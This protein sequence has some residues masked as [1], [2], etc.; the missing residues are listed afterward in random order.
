MNRKEALYKFITDLVSNCSRFGERATDSYR[1]VRIVR[2]TPIK[3]DLEGFSII[4]NGRAN[5]SIKVE[6]QLGTGSDH[7]KASGDE[8]EDLLAELANAKAQKFEL[9]NGEIHVVD[10][11][12]L[13]YYDATTK[14]QTLFLVEF[15][16]LYHY[17]RN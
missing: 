2:Q 12:Y 8:F 1:E 10:L 15:N 17:K 5:G 4:E 3:V 14:A 11:E 6:K 9:D 7:V 13:D 16:L